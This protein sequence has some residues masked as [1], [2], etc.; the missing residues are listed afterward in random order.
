MAPGRAPAG[1]SGEGEDDFVF[2]LSRDE[3]LDLLFDDLE[4]PNLVRNQLM[5]T[6]EF[7]PVRAGYTT[8]G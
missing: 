3:F 6:T 2:E 4:L 7:K 8:D 1:N 5:G